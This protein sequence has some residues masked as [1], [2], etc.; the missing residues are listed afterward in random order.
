MLYSLP[1]MI[2]LER[3]PMGKEQPI[4]TPCSQFELNR[5]FGCPFHVFSKMVNHINRCYIIMLSTMIKIEVQFFFFTFMNIF[6]QLRVLTVLKIN[7][8][9]CIFIT[10]ALWF[11]FQSVLTKFNKNNVNFYFNLNAMPQWLETMVWT[12]MT[13]LW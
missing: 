6:S 5:V 4:F 12:L 10:H 11:F 3:K 8:S 9:W 7:V 13:R 1:N 2:C